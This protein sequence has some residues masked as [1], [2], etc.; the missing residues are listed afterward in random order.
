MNFGENRSTDISGRMSPSPTGYNLGMS[1][2]MKY[3]VGLK[4]TEIY[5]HIYIYEISG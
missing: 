4:S 2:L 5:I 1:R 3:G